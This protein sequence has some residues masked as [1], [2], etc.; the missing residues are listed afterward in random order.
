MSEPIPLCLS[1]L[2]YT[3]AFVGV[4]AVF[5]ACSGLVGSFPFCATFGAYGFVFIA[6]NFKIPTANMAFNVGWFR[7]Q[8]IPK[9]RAGFGF[10]FDWFILR[11]QLSHLQF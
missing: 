2:Y 9:S 10:L 4:L 5:Q 1:G 7:L 6:P 3:S 8:E 11:A